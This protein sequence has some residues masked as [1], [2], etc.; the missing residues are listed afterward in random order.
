MDDALL[1][2][3]SAAAGFMPEEEGLALYRAGLHAA[4]LGP[5][6]EIGSYRGKSAVYLGAA[7]RGGSSVLY[8]IDHHVGSEEHQPGEGYHDPDLFDEDLGRINSLPDF[9]ATIRMAELEDVVAP[10]IGSSPVIARTW[11][12]PLSLV[13][14]DGGHSD[15]AARAD[16]EGWSPKIIPGG[17]LAIHD[18][19]ENP[20]DGGRPPYEIYREALASGS[21]TDWDRTGSLRVLLRTTDRS[22]GSRRGI[23]GRRSRSSS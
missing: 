7:A 4:P 8:S 15:V 13:F 20:A 18:V 17:L 23:R 11:S 16:L 1:R 21:F 9:L 19:F 14:I 6:L 2:H 5:M 22:G 12:I 3:A 10:I